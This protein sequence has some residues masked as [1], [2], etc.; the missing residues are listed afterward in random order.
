[1][2]D[3]GAQRPKG[4]KGDNG[5]KG[6]TGTQGT[7]GPKGDKGDSGPQ[8]PQGWKGDTGDQGPQGT[9]GVLAV[10]DVNGNP[11]PLPHLVTGVTKT[12]EGKVYIELKEKAVFTDKSSY[13]CQ[14]TSEDGKGSLQVIYYD[15]AHFWVKNT[16][17]Q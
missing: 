11:M 7:Q 1:K 17:E 10:F 15:G 3:T 12:F 16:D 6:D 8:G 13:L 9:S 4:D 5:A 14:V 2:G